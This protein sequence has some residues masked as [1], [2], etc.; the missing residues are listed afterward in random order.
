MYAQQMKPVAMRVAILAA[1]VLMIWTTKHGLAQD[2]DRATPP[3]IGAVRPLKLPPL[4]SLALR[5]GI[6]VSV[7]EKHGAPLVELHLMYRCGSADDPNATPGLASMTAAMMME[8][9]GTRTALEL[10]DAIDFLGARID[11]DATYHTTTVSLFTP[12]PPVQKSVD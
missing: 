3:K 2:A 6:P 12:R 8:G 10:A 1:F 5:N 11:V 4:Q 7:M 9:A